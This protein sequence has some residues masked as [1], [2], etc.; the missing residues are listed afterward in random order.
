[1]YVECLSNFFTRFQFSSS[2]NILDFWYLYIA[3]NFGVLLEL[4][5]NTLVVAYDCHNL[6]IFDEITLAHLPQMHKSWVLQT[7]NQSIVTT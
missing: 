4:P 5:P 6:I 7:T 1:M 3:Q 2:S